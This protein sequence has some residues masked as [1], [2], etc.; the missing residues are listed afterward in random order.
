[1]RLTPF[2]P[3]GPPKH[4]FVVGNELV[5]Q[6]MGQQT[7]YLSIIPLLLPYF[8]FE[9]SLYG[10]VRTVTSVSHWSRKERPR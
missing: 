6:G 10:S 5:L 4:V 1:M 8:P 2:Y 3:V 7:Y 9:D